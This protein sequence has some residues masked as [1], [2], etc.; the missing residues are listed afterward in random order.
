MAETIDTGKETDKT[1]KLLSI[2]SQLYSELHPQSTQ[3]IKLKLNSFLDR[4]LGFDSLSRVELILRI[5]RTF[6]INLP[7]KL[8]AEAETINDLLL[9][10]V[11]DSKSLVHNLKGEFHHDELEDVTGLPS[12]AETL[13]DILDWHCAAHPDRTHIYLYG[14]GNT[15]EEISH[16]DLFKGARKI[17]TGLQVKGLSPGGTVAIMLPTSHDYLY[18][19]FGILMAGGIPV[20]I[21]PPVR[22]SQLEDHLHRHFGILNNAR[23]QFLITV[24]EARSVARLMKA[25]VEELQ[26]IVTPTELEQTNEVFQTIP[27]HT[28]DLAF[29]QYTSGSTGQPKGVTLTHKQLLANIRAMGEA[30]KADFTD[31]FVS[32]LPLYHDM[33]LIGAWF[34]SLYHG[35]PLVLMSPLAFLSHP[36]RW[37]WTIHHHRATL[38]AAPN[39]AYELCLN[40][41]LDS[42]IEGLDLSSWRMA[43]NGAEAISPKT[44]RGFNDR[45][46]Q[47]GLKKTAM[48]PV[49][50]LAEAAVG[51]AF[52]PVGRG[53]LIDR[54]QREHFLSKGEALP[55]HPG[56]A[57]DTSDPDILEQV[58]SGQPLRG[59]QIRIVDS[60]GRERP[61]RHEGRVQFMGPSATEGYFHNP[62]ATQN[63]FDGSWLDIGDLGYIARGDIYLTSRSKDLIIRGGRNIYPYELEEA[64][65]NIHGVRKGC[66][67]VFGSKDPATGTERLIVVAETREPE[68]AWE[69]IRQKIMSAAIDLLGMPP[70]EVVLAPPQ[71]VLKT[72]SG[73]IRRSAVREVFEKG[74]IKQK[75]RAVW[76]QVARLVLTSIRPRWRQLRHTLSDTIYAFYMKSFFWLLVPLV[77]LLVALLPGKHLRW[78]LIHGSSRLLFRLTAIPLKVDGVEHIEET[79]CVFIANHSSYLD[80]LVLAAVLPGEPEFVAKRELEK[81]FFSRIFLKRI[82]AVYVDR[83]DRQRGVLDARQTVQ[84]LH[85]NQSLIYYPEG[86]L[87]RAPGLLPFHMGAFIAAAEAMAPVVPVVIHGTRSILRSGSWF[88]HHGSVHVQ[89]CEPLL[90]ENKDWA[91]AVKLRDRSR[92][93]FLKLLN[94]PDLATDHSPV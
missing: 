23:T 46:V 94:E 84:T 78:R 6:D 62:E 12:N 76:M 29:L 36:S 90:P 48:S 53:M 24:P 34:G 26:A 60:S 39:F 41:I 82:G 44:L 89:I 56:N 1:E 50:G 77:W 80:S 55:A 32:W 69:P 66:S 17:A 14:E 28:D 52:P 59:Y 22:L 47:Y 40:K 4:D 86:T 19:F 35:M 63:M 3:P 93:T 74:L 31:T 87:V 30:V 81:K 13:L 5:E 72:S 49:Y 58:A 57:G 43:F 70:D 10:I 75:P 8:L 51:L 73:K 67:A 61:E 9:A 37:L 7:E 25:Q 15:P 83:F 27:L 85:N 45:F 71:T 79:P 33:G 88:P 21:Y 68:S 20:P 54:I 65:G 92:N 11:P 91:S 38:S 64:T 16:A 2:I 42:E 18:S